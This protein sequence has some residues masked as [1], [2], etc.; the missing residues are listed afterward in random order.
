MY[1]QKQESLP[2]HIQKTCRSETAVT[3]FLLVKLLKYNG[4]KGFMLTG[5]PSMSQNYFY[6]MHISRGWHLLLSAY[7]KILAHIVRSQLGR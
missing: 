3:L 7:T 1:M 4:L 2:E 6:K 5:L